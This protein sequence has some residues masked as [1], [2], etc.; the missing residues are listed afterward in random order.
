MDG[1]FVPARELHRHR[2][3]VA[4]IEQAE[5]GGG[6]KCTATFVEREGH[7]DDPLSFRESH[8]DVAVH[9]SDGSSQVGSEELTR[10]LRGD[11]EALGYVGAGVA[12][13]DS[14]GAVCVGIRDKP[15]AFDFD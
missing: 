13:T 11:A 5:Q 7:Q 9:A 2:C 6:L 4:G 1:F 8:T 12:D 15:L 10:T 14:Q 3:V